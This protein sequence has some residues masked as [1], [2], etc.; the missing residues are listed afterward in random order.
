MFALTLCGDSTKPN[1]LENHVGCA[2]YPKAALL[3]RG[4][5]VNDMTTRKERRVAESN[6]ISAFCG[7][8]E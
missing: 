5:E 4:D 1:S 3:K 8:L 7:G 2:W 6:V